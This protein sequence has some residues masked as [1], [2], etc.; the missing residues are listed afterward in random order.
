MVLVRQ[1]RPTGLEM[2][3]TASTLCSMINFLSRRQN[4]GIDDPGMT[5]G[6]LV[7]QS[8]STI[9]MKTRSRQLFPKRGH[10]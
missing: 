1:L 2:G 7:T 5:Y 6:D 9:L 3:L 10:I 4:D 8:C